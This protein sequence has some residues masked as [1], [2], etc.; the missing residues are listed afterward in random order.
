MGDIITGTPPHLTYGHGL[1]QQAW[2]VVWAVASAALVVILGWMGLP[3]SSP[4]TW[5]GPRPGGGR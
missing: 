5:D 2:T 1:V 3:S 4:S